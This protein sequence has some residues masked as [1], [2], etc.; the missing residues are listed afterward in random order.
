MSKASGLLLIMAGLGAAAYVLAGSAEQGEQASSQRTDI[1]KSPSAATINV[2]TVTKPGRADQH[3]SAAT[4]VAPKPQPAVA[5]AFRPVP[6]ALAEAPPAPTR[7]VIATLEQRASEPSRLPLPPAQ[8]AASV[9]GDRASL[10]RELQ[11][12]LKRVGCY[13]GE[14]NA[15]WT[16]ST[17]R[18]MKA[19]TDRVNATLPVEEPDYILLALVQGHHDRA[20][21][22]PCPAG[23]SLSEAGRCLSD[24]ILARA[25]TKGSA[26]VSAATAPKGK[27]PE[28]PAPAITAWSTNTTVAA[29]A[30]PEPPPEGRMA[31][32]G[33][34]TDTSPP[35]AAAPMSSAGV[36]VLPG[37]GG[38]VPHHGP[39]P[40]AA[41]Y[42]RRQAP[43]YVQ[44]APRQ[45]FNAKAFFHKLDYGR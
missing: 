4:V 5:P 35:T 12:E 11:R 6:P 9:P 22:K 32:A 28:P 10:A 25:T 17:R 16:T 39:V 1:V 3:P 23:Q 44:Q 36:A 40:P 33:P 19:F 20:C 24:A 31:L 18:A 30:R 34:Q 8:K 2:A 41:V 26:R 7:S 21:G 15:T 45:R 29:P 37:Q 43:R 27:A 42:E 13:D 38:A 14:I